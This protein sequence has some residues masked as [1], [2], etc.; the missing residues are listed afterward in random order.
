MSNT[1]G[2][3]KLP[4]FEIARFERRTPSETYPQIRDSQRDVFGF[5]HFFSALNFK[6]LLF[7]GVR[8]VA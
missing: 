8:A 1:E 6:E 3:E 5:D 2:T 4:L 7:Y